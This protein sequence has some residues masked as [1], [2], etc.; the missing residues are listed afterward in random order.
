MIIKFQITLDKNENTMH[1]QFSRNRKEINAIAKENRE[2]LSKNLLGLEEKLSKN[3]KDVKQTIDTQLG[4]IRKDNTKQLDKMRNTV[5][6]KLQD[7]L[8]KR[9]GKSFKLVSDRLEEVHK[10]LGQMQTIASGVGDLKSVLKNVK[11]RGV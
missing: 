1:D 7:T 6:E 3:F 9:I 2:E 10:G 8:E 11:T 5:D 4:D